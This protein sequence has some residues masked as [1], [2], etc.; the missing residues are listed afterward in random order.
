V[1]VPDLTFGLRTVRAL[2]ARTDALLDVH[3]MVARPEEY[4]RGLADAGANRVC[5]HV[6]AAAYPW[7][8]VSLGRS[9]G[10]EVGAAL[11]PATPLAVLEALASSVDFVNLLTTEPD[12]SGELVLPGMVERVERA[13]RD[14]PAEVRLEVDGGVD[15]RTVSAFAA[16]DDLVAGR[17]ICGS[18][19]WST[20][21]AELRGLLGVSLR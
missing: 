12:F 9:L 4:L 3:L 16:A 19:D 6:E 7:R 21:V 13:R 17:A 20:T 5:F 15:E 1:F 8:L 11:N 2:R 14:L 18:E 10:L